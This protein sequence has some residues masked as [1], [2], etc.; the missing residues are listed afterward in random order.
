MSNVKQD[1]NLY[2]QIKN[3]KN[4]FNKEM[5]IV[6]ANINLNNF[7]I[8]KSGL[9]NCDKYI[10]DM[11]TIINKLPDKSTADFIKPLVPAILSF[12]TAVGVGLQFN[13]KLFSSNNKIVDMEDEIRRNNDSILSKED[14]IK[15]LNK[16][17]SLAS[18]EIKSATYCGMG[19]FFVNIYKEKYESIKEE[20]DKLLK[21]VNEIADKNEEIRNNINKAKNESDTIN[22][23]HRVFGATTLG[24]GAVGTLISLK[25]LKSKA[26]SILNKCKKVLDDTRKY[27]DKVEKMSKAVKESFDETL[28]SIYE[29][30]TEGTIDEFEYDT[31]MDHLLN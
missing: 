27:L 18:K 24:V 7:S 21:E 10:S 20:C 4:G 14:A 1:L 30:F 6:K 19:E 29:S 8:A 16:K 23:N 25:P 26:K 2:K 12:V 31:L 28:D 3:I 17:K 22:R 5:K 11:E 15:E 9:N 13:R